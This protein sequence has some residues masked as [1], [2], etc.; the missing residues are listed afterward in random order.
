M[1]SGVQHRSPALARRWPHTATQ[2]HWQERGSTPAPSQRNL[3][4]SR[5]YRHPR[6]WA[7]LCIGAIIQKDCT[8]ARRNHLW[9]TKPNASENQMRGALPVIARTFMRTHVCTAHTRTYA[10]TRRWWDLT[11]NVKTATAS[12]EQ[13]RL[14]GKKISCRWLKVNDHS[15]ETK[16][17]LDMNLTIKAWIWTGSW[18][19]CDG[20]L[21][22]RAE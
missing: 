9:P 8:P 21:M 4:V 20:W 10:H 6:Y 13:H 16:Q 5:R 7:H 15:R 12:A 1:R 18:G 11:N 2:D 14:L 17:H 22:R 19:S 3:S